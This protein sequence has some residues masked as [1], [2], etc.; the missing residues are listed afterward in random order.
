MPYLADQVINLTPKINKRYIISSQH[1]RKGN[2]KKC[3]W[4]ITFNE[5]VDCF[6]QAINQNWKD[7]DEAWGLKLHNTTLQILGE[8]ND[9]DELKLAK[10]IDGNNNDIWHGYPADHMNRPQDIPTEAILK[11]WVSKH[12]I[13]K[14]KMNKIRRGQAC[15]L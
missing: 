6:I 11:I 5:E 2:P 3:V 15:S 14:S 13:T 1:R 7:G 12:Y 8:N 10:F 4:I 9:N